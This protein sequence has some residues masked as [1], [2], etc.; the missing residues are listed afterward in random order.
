MKRN[1]EPKHFNFGEHIDIFAALPNTD[2]MTGDMALKATGHAAQKSNA[3]PHSAEASRKLPGRRDFQN[4]GT[5]EEIQ[6]Y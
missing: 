2:S 4:G 5:S 6:L 1:T 3:K